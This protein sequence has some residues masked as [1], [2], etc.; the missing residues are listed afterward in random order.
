MDGYDKDRDELFDRL[1]NFA[2]IADSTVGILR[3][4]VRTLRQ[5]NAQLREDMG[6][7]RLQLHDALTHRCKCKEKKRQKTKPKTIEELVETCGCG[8]ETPVGGL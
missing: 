2:G 8:Q 5:E 7:L 6:R 4:Q 1:L 3:T